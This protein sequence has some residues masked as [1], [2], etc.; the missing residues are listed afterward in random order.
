MKEKDVKVTSPK[1][2]G[3]LE[4]KLSNQELDYVWRCIKDKKENVND[5]L[6]G[7]ISE[8]NRLSDKSDWFW[9]NVIQHLVI[10]YSKEFGN[11]GDRAP[12][13]QRHPYYL[14]TWWVN[15][16][17]QYEFNP[18]H[19]HN[20]VYSFVIWMKIPTFWKEQSKLPIAFNSN[21]EI[22]II[23]NFQLE[24]Q[25]ILGRSR[26]ITYMMS[27][28]KE[29]TM[30]FFPSQLQHVVYPF[31]NCDEDRISVSGNVLINTTKRL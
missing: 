13:N 29:G 24:Y 18:M 27:P 16:Q 2:Y 28:E 8:S 10:R 22:D 15:Y 6:A 21:N 1:N 9:M 20:G 7:N 31:Y 11:P 17:K 30:I 14:H 3:L 4:Y 25:D 26:K 19:D 23:S 5:Q 12:N